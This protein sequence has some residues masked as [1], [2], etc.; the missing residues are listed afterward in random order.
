MKVLQANLSSI[1]VMMGCYA[2]EIIY[3]RSYF[4]KNCHRLCKGDWRKLGV[5]ADVH[6]E[7]DVEVWCF[8][9]SAATDL[10]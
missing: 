9:S 6:D 7:V 8:I 1:D 5:R 4:L 10:R 2:K 3:T